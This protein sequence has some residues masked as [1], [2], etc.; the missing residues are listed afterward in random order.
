MKRDKQQLTIGI[1]AKRSGVGVETVKFYQRK[2]LLPKPS[3]PLGGG[4]RH[5]QLEDIT[6]IRF[7]KRAQDLGFT[8]REAKELLEIN[9]KPAATCSDIKTKA[10][11]KLSEVELK[12]QDLNRVKAAL[13]ELIHA[14]G[15]S[16]KAAVNCRVMNC[17]ELECEC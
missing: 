14:C 9:T 12:I 17:F 15:D 3:K 5:Y 13:E 8:L 4:F 6:R 2:G 7:I 10:K 1:L 11:S 16:K